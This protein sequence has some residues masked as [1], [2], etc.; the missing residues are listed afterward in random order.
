MFYLLTILVC[1]M[2]I[3][4]LNIIFSIPVFGFSEIY[5]IFAVIISTVAE[6]L[7][8]GLFAGIVRWM[9][10]KKWFTADKNYFSASKKEM[11]FYEKIGIKKWKD[12]VLELGCFTSFRKNKISDPRNL[13]YVESYILEANYGVVVH[14]VLIVVSFLVVFMYPLKYWYCFGVPVAIVSVVL[15]ILP[16]F[17][18][19]YNLPKLYVLRKI[20][21]K[22][23][24]NLNKVS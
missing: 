14:L 22:R 10:P 9:L 18:L 16:L 4:V 3:A 21:S 24:K 1:M 8:N 15:N 11:L 20:N 12:K 19:R 7:L 2:I 13:E 6:I 23:N 17:I 5:I